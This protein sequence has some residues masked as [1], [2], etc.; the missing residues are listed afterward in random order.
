MVSVRAKSALGTL[1]A[2][3]LRLELAGWIERR[4]G[5]IY[6]AAPAAAE[7]KS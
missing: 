5:G 7:R 3:L 1:Q 6:R 2:E 4:P